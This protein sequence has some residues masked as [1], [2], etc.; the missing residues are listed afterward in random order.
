MCWNESVSLNTFIFGLFATGFALYNNV[1]PVGQAIG[2]MSF[3]SI[4]LI[5]YFT[6]VNINNRD[7]IA[8]LS[9]L[10]LGLVLV[11][12]ALIHTFVLPQNIF[13]IFLAVYAVFL[14]LTL[15]V[16][17]PIKDIIF[18]MH[19]AANGHL[20]WDWLKIPDILVV[21]WMCFFI[22]PLLYSKYY[23]Y[24]AIMIAS[25]A[26]IFATYKTSNTWGSMWC[27]IAN[28][29]SIYLIGKVFARELC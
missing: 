18:L 16:W 11:Q 15:T 27:W 6:W 4:Q 9:K 12:P 28:V 17:H 8:L 14:T 21:G 2:I 19:K 7:A 13:H 26:I 22:W 10:G 20:A 3:V 23:I 29:C 24:S 25:A 1:I 5:E